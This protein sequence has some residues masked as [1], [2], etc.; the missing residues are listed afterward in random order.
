MSLEQKLGDFE[1]L[2]DF[3][4]KELKLMATFMETRDYA[5]GEEIIGKDNANHSLFFILS[6][7]VRIYRNFSGGASF[8]T[9]IGTKEVF[10][11]VAFADQQGRTALAEA[12]G[13]VEIALFDYDHFNII[14]KQDPVFGMKLLLELLKLLA[15]KFRVVNKKLDSIFSQ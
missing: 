4:T 14:K 15:T 6:G 13:A 3:T 7:K 1:I 12:V 9:Q 8:S 5:D 10:G 2:K 11:E